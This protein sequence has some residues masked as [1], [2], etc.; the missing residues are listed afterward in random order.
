[1]IKAGGELPSASSLLEA[2][3]MKNGKI[4]VWRHHLYS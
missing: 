2:G 3:G 1:M 4:V